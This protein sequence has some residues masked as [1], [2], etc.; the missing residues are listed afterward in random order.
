MAKH[1]RAPRWAAWGVWHSVLFVAAACVAIFEL[2]L[3][4]E[5]A[6]HA[7]ALHERHA[8]VALDVRCDVR[9][10]QHAL[11]ADSLDCAPA[12]RTLAKGARMLALECVVAR[13]PFASYAHIFEPLLY[14][15]RER[16]LEWLQGAGA[17]LIALFVVA[18]LLPTLLAWRREERLHDDLRSAMHAM[19]RAGAAGASHYHI[20]PRRMPAQNRIEEVE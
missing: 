20:A 6:P 16:T 18:W 4:R 7:R 2:R 12:R 14:P 1:A 9:T 5:C 11:F 15:A 17:A 13:H 8:A 3:W 19:R 10:P